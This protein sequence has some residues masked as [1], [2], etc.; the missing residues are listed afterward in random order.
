MTYVA[1][2]AAAYLSKLDPDSQ[3]QGLSRM[4]AANP[5]LFQMVQQILMSRTGQQANPMNAMQMPLPDKKPQRRDMAR[6]IGG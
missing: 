5:E 4:S 3:S 2:R 1:K 6:R